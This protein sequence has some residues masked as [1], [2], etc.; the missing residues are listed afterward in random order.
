[1]DISNLDDEY[2]PAVFKMPP[3][4]GD[5][6]KYKPD[7]SFSTNI[8][9][10]KFSLGFHHFIHQSKDKMEITKEFEGK[11]QVYLVFNKFEVDVDNYESSIRELAT[12]YFGKGTYI[13]SR[14]FYKL[15]ELFFMFDL[16]P[17]TGNF[18]SAHLA[19]G[20]GSFIQATMF[21]RDMFAKGNKNDKYYAVT[22]HPEQKKFVPP[23]DEKFAN[24][25]SRIH[26]EKTYP[27]S[28]GKVN[29]DLTDK[30]TIAQVG[31]QFKDSKAHFITADGGFEW[32]NENVQ[33]QEAF[34]LIL[35]EIITAVKI[36]GKGGNF[37]CKIF[38][39]FTEVTVKFILILQSFYAE[40]YAVKPLTSRRSNSE[41]YL[42]CL[43]FKHGESKEKDSAIAKLEDVLEQSNKS[44][45]NMVSLFP[46][47]NINENTK[48]AIIK[49]N[50][51]IAN[52]Q[53]IRIN[54]IVDFIQKQN[55]RGDTYQNRR[56][57]QIEANKY[58]VD[59][60]LPEAKAFTKKVNE[61][62]KLVDTV[63]KNNTEGT[64]KLKDKL[65]SNA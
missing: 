26:V 61:M 36:Q 8:D 60:F 45:L 63:V 30:K 1:M 38:E 21:F 23:I 34:N 29:G 11:K 64:K 52:F 46:D 16:V 25:D 47:Y 31:G 15:W 33:E 49:M 59:K 40:V 28:S 13:L 24:S 62:T 3:A 55:Y 39:S 14:A 18:V 48:T 42:V 32:K 17:L 12:Q 50:T 65:E 22:L 43:G 4:E 2:I 53:F 6:F 56:E 57:M 10:P 35:G 9:Y 41:K 19:E 20:P 54:Q 37:V 7:P 51:S 27:R 5:I 44:G 58:W